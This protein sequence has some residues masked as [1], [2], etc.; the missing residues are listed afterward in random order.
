MKKWDFYVP[1]FHFNIYKKNKILKK[2]KSSFNTDTILSGLANISIGRYMS[3]MR[4]DED[5]FDKKF[6]KD[7]NKKNDIKTK[8]YSYMVDKEPLNCTTSV[9]KENQLVINLN[10][11]GI[12]YLMPSFNFIESTSSYFITVD[13]KE[14]GSYLTLT[15]YGDIF[16]YII[17]YKELGFSSSYRDEIYI[18]ELLKIY[19]PLTMKAILKDNKIIVTYEKYNKNDPQ[20]IENIK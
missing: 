20:R 17:I 9:T 18:P 14:P 6:N 2:I 12:K 15:T 13:Y 10:F 8:Q 7:Y 1:F 5:T 11:T 3:Q 19:D 4:K 16:E